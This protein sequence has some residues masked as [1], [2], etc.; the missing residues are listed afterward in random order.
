MHRFLSRVIDSALLQLMGRSYSARQR[1]HI[2]TEATLGGKGFRVPLMAGIG[3]QN[4]RL[5][6]HD[7]QLRRVAR[8]AMAH[9][10]GAILDVGCNIGHF[11]QLCLLSDRNRRYVGLDPNPACCY[12]LETFIRENALPAHSVLPVG[13]SNRTEALPLLKNGPFDVCATVNG[14]LNL[15]TRFRTRSVTVTVPGDLLVPQLGLEEIALVKIDVEG[16]ELEVLQGLER[17]LARHRPLIAFEVLL[18]ADL[19]Q[20]CPGADDR[21]SALARERRQ[22]ALDLEAFF[23]QRGYALFRIRRDT[24]LAPLETLDPGNAT[25]HSEMDHLA[26]PEEEVR[27][28]LATYAQEPPLAGAGPSAVA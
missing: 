26:V 13:L 12:Y 24:S 2:T 27:A 22:R 10:Q 15:E 21:V 5:A 16:H 20:T 9:R 3:E 25:D 19:G 17:T 23:R 1:L 14:K 7:S 8:N 18:Y 11:M 4:C 6:P 28:F